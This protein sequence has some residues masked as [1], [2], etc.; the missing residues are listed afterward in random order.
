MA[1]FTA[2]H[3]YNYVNPYLTDATGILAVAACVYAIVTRRFAL[4]SV[5]CVLGVGVRETLLFVS[6]G[7]ATKQ[8]RSAGVTITSSL[9]GYFAI[10]QWIGPL[11]PVEPGP[12]KEFPARPMHA[13]VTELILS[14]HGLW[15]LA[16]LGLS[17]L[18]QQRRHLYFMGSLLCA[19]TLVTSFLASDTTRMTQPLFPFVALGVAR[20]LEVLWER[21][22]TLTTLVVGSSVAASALWQPVRVIA[23]SAL[24]PTSPLSMLAVAALCVT[25]LAAAASVIRPWRSRTRGTEAYGESAADAV[26][27]AVAVN[28]HP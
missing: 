11:G 10:R 28:E 2:P 21:S 9:A 16:P 23:L 18:V 25:A 3:L 1:I 12:F 8:R 20:I 13:I 22:R 6:P 24:A 5:V 4:F 15:V 26:T 17:L 14:W 19:G 7:W 27:G